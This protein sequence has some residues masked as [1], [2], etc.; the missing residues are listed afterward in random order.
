MALLGTRVNNTS[1]KVKGRTRLWR[2]YPS[3]NVTA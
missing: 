1:R 2:K 3:A